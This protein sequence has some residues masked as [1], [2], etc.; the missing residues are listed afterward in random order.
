MNMNVL[1]I[2]NSE[3]RPEVDGCDWFY[4]DTGNLEVRIAPLSCWEME[5]CLAIH[6]LIESILCKKAGISQT[7]VDQFDLKFDRDHP[8]EPDIGAGDDPDAPYHRQHIVA[9]TIE[10]IVAGELNLNWEE[11]EKELGLRYPGPSKRAQ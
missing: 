7:E 11:Y 6:E 4:D 2:P 5:T 1:V 10:R 8:N 3:M 9:T